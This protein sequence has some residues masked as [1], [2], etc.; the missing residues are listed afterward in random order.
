LSIFRSPASVR[1]NGGQLVSFVNRHRADPAIGQGLEDLPEVVVDRLENLREPLARFHVDFLIPFSLS[2]L[3]SSN[4]A[5]AKASGPRLR[6]AGA[7]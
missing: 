7:N 2:R 1:R 5:A 4:P 3:E 6:R